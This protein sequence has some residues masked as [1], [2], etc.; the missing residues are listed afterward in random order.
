MPNKHTGSNFEDFYNTEVKSYMDIK[1]LEKLMKLAKKYGVTTV[2]TE[3]I[4]FTI[5]L[6]PK[7]PKKRQIALEPHGVS[8]SDRIDMPNLPSVEDL[9][10]YS[11][12][13]QQ[14]PEEQ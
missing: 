7:E 13:G 5:E 2:K 3:S 10:F 1:Y 9:L 6:S 14:P 12:S 4:E 11:A 8:E